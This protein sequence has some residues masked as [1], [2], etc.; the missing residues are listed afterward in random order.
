MNGLRR[1]IHTYSGIL[2]SHKKNEIM[3]FAATWMQLEILILSEVSQKEKD[4]YHM[5]SLVCGIWNMAQRIPV[6]AQW[7]PIRLGTMRLWVQFLA[8]LSGLRIWHW[9]ELRCRLQMQL[10][11]GVAVAVAGSYSSNWTPSLGTSICCG[12]GPKKDKK[13]KL[14]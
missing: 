12:H 10:G 3:P 8:S 13:L 2:L 1:C 6:M 4:K 14:K 7:K 5:M 9:R 11:S